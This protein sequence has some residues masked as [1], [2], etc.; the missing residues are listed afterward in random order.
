MSESKH[1][2][3]NGCRFFLFNG[4]RW[5]R[6]VLCVVTSHLHTIIFLHLFFSETGFDFCCCRCCLANWHDFFSRASC[7]L[8]SGIMSAVTCFWQQSVYRRLILVDHC[9]LSWGKPELCSMGLCVKLAIESWGKVSALTNSV[10]RRKE[11][12]T[13]SQL[14]RSLVVTW[15]DQVYSTIRWDLVEGP[16]HVELSGT[17]W[18]V[19]GQ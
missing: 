18:G 5:W 15:H 14:S 19:R 1:K 10:G 11:V 8:I 12:T 9:A 13:R 7:W 4:Q 6:V 16:H 17:E 2:K 3:N